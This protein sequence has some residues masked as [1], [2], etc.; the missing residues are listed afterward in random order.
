MTRLYRRQPCSQMT[1]A[2]NPDVSV[3]H[4][5]PVTSNIPSISAR[6]RTAR[7]DSSVL[8]N[9]IT[10]ICPERRGLLELEGWSVK[11]KM[12]P[13]VTQFK[14]SNR[15]LYNSLKYVWNKTF[16]KWWI[17]TFQIFRK[18]KI[19][20]EWKWKILEIFPNRHEQVNLLELVFRENVF[21]R[22]IV[23][24]ANVKKSKYVNSLL[25]KR[26]ETKCYRQT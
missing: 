18:M 25:Y 5:A 13:E 24:I 6:Y 22:Q 20:K 9:Y 15:Y 10:Q 19:V 4:L 23:Q 16:F 3:G 21:W 1:I 8:P 11:R 2:Q 7:G 26:E 17:Y 14:L 12:S